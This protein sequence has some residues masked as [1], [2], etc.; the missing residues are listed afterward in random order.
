MD[1]INN[2]T[3]PAP[4]GPSKQSH[5]ALKAVMLV[6]LF[7]STFLASTTM[8]APVEKECYLFKMR[9]NFVRSR[10]TTSPYMGGFLSLASCFAA[11]V[12]LATCLLD[13]LPDVLNSWARAD[14]RVRR[15]WGVADGPSRPF[16]LCA[17]FIAVGFLLVLVLEQVAQCALEWVGQRAAAGGGSLLFTDGH[18]HQRSPPPPQRHQTVQ[19][20]LQQQLQHDEGGHSGGGG[21]RDSQRQPLL[22][23][24]HQHQ[25]LSSHREDGHGSPSFAVAAEHHQQLATSMADQQHHDQ[26][27]HSSSSVQHQQQQLGAEEEQ[28]HQQRHNGAEN[29]GDD[30]NGTNAGFECQNSNLQALKQEFEN[31]ESL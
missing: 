7:F 12:F 20:V 26:P 24:E 25:I 5:D 10:A 13:M 11:G 29:S 2:E 18:H 15:W 30:G 27:Q 22:G 1:A 23:D 4:I 19:S 17:L 21:R 9:R 14:Q 3:T 31:L 6:V 16:P 28:Q 8:G